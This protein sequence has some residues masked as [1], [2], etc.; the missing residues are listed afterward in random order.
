MAPA[1]SNP[2][3][4]GIFI[5]LGSNLGDRAGTLSA[6][7]E[8]LGQTP[9]IRLV[10]RSG[11]HETVAVGGPSGQPDYLNAA[12]ELESTLAPEELLVRLQE[13]EN[14]FLRRREIPNGP[15]T[16]DL[17]L[18][19]FGDQRRNDPQLQ[20]PHP[21]M[22]SRPFVLEPLS[23]ICDLEALRKRFL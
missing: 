17:D 19:I 1:A 5:G 20:L 3:I 13:I 14:A 8:R 18:L 16:L 9:G 7:L 11:F 2:P 15:R 23:E 4:R 10:A 21:R 12:A 22:W 6:A